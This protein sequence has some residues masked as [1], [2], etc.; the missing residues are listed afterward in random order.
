[1]HKF[2]FQYRNS[3]ALFWYEEIKNW[4]NYQNFIAVFVKQCKI[5]EHGGFLQSQSHLTYDC[6]QLLMFYHLKTRH[7]VAKYYTHVASLK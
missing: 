5:H 3:K 6:K 7:H 2:H 1:M 4:L